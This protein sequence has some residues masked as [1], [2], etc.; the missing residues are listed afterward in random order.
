MCRQHRH[1]SRAENC[2][3]LKRHG[4]VQATGPLRTTIWYA[5]THMDTA[6][7]TDL[8]ETLRED[9]GLSR[10]GSGLSQLDAYWGLE[11]RLDPLDPAAASLLCYV[12]QWVDAGWRDV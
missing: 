4:M 6:D 9:L 7:R 2:Y 1:F 3:L 11:R 10:I 12:A 8:L 5:N